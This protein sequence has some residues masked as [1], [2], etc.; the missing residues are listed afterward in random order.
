[1]T[2]KIN[3]IICYVGVGFGCASLCILP[4]FQFPVPFNKR[5]VLLI[6]TTSPATHHPP[7]SSLLISPL[8]LPFLFLLSLLSI[9]RSPLRLSDL[10]VISCTALPIQSPR[11]P[12]Q[13]PQPLIHLTRRCQIHIHPQ[14]WQVLVWLCTSRQSDFSYSPSISPS[15]AYSPS[16]LTL[17]AAYTLP[18]T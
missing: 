14:T 9:F 5:R 12:T 4:P 1:M 16:Y 17:H 10:P 11:C 18:G 6:S 15:I 3:K 2:S 8:P 7:P 13:P